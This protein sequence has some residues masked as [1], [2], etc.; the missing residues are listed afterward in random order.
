MSARTE[1]FD[2]CENNLPKLD[3][4]QFDA[5]DADARARML[6]DFNVGQV[7]SLLGPHYLV[8]NPPAPRHDEFN[9][10]KVKW[11]AESSKEDQ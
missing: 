1:L 11:Q 6:N 5:F 8:P 9:A 2:Y 10:L 3:P 7:F 4:K